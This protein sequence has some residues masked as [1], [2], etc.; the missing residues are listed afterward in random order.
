MKPQSFLTFTLIYLLAGNLSA[1]EFEKDVLPIFQSKCSR[2][3][4]D[5]SSKGGVSL[6]LD[7]IDRDIGSGKAIVPGDVEKSDLFEVVSLPQEDGD[8]MP[9]E[10][11]GRSLSDRELATLKEWIEGGAPLE[12]EAKEMEVAEEE[13]E[14]PKKPEPIS[15]SWT[16][17]D[18]VVIEATLMRVEGD[19]AVLQMANGRV[20]NY[21]IANLSDES[22][23]K[24]KEFQAASS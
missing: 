11:K 15:G 13:P 10:G 18:G 4:M 24:I 22:Q 7:K 9:P 12:G 20:Y 21:P 5:G 14:M 19:K 17:R 6:D 3:H 16:N 2:C 23:A 8:A 1:V